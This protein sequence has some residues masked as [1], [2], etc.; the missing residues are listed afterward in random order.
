MTIVL[1]AL[2]FACDDDFGPRMGE[3][4]LA[5]PD[6]TFFPPLLAGEVAEGDPSRTTV[7]MPGPGLARIGR[8]V[9]RLDG[10]AVSNHEVGGPISWDTGYYPPSVETGHWQVIGAF[11]DRETFRLR[12]TVVSLDTNFRSGYDESELW[13]PLDYDGTWIAELEPD[14]A[15]ELPP[16]YRTECS[17][18][19][20]GTAAAALGAWLVVASRRRG[21]RP[22]VGR[23]APSRR[24]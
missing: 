7:T 19:P 15:G 4:E 9:L 8:H 18:A 11:A 12:I 16:D 21:R 13:E 2:F 3:Y 5:T 23:A 6:P 14:T 1:A 17:T 24:E 10:R 20:G 22:V